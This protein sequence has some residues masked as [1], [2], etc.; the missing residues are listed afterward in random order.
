M[1]LVD[2]LLEEAFRGGRKIV[3]TQPEKEGDYNFEAVI[4]FRQLYPLG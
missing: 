1:L 3:R 2:Y 4:V